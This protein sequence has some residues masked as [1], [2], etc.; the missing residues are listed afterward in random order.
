MMKNEQ[1][2]FA[3]LSKNSARKEKKEKQRQLQNFYKITNNQQNRKKKQKNS[4]SNRLTKRQ[5]KSKKVTRQIQ[6]VKLWGEIK[7]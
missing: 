7:N 4:K 5:F 3:S 6:K 1:K 2:T